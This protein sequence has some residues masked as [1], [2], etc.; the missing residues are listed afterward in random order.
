MEPCHLASLPLAVNVQCHSQRH[1]EV[2]L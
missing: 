1:E 2:E